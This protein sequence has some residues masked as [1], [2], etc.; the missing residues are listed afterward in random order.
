MD[1]TSVTMNIATKQKNVRLSFSLVCGCQTIL[2]CFVKKK[3]MDG[4]SFHLLI[5]FQ[6][7]QLVLCCISW[8]AMSLFHSSIWV[9][10]AYLDTVYCFA[11]FFV[12]SNRNEH[13]LRTS[14]PLRFFT[15]PFLLLLAGCYQL[16]ALS[17]ICFIPYV[18]IHQITCVIM[19]VA[20]K[21]IS[22]EFNLY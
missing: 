17:L 9:N 21:K 16:K 3:K 18:M 15:D 8:E 13:G 20:A 22:R 14:V 19:G 5:A 1:V 12:R 2:E 6:R 11:F 7:L 4:P 10:S